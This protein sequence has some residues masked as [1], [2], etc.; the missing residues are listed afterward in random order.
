MRT[1][2]EITEVIERTV[3]EIIKTG[4]ITDQI[5]SEKCKKYNI[6]EDRIREIGYWKKKNWQK[7]YKQQVKERQLKQIQQK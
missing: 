7:V 2:K 1:Q 5:I 6:N 3:T 4:N